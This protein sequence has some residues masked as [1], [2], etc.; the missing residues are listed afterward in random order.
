MS[1]STPLPSSPPSAS[2]A[3]RGA[4]R[5]ALRRA[6]AWST[7]LVLALYVLNSL[8][9]STEM[10]WGGE[11]AGHLPWVQEGTAILAVLAGLPLALWLGHRF[12]LERGRLRLSL[13][14]HA[15][16]M[17][18]YA[19]VQIG[20]MMG[21]R[22]LLWPVL[23]GRGYMVDGHWADVFVY[24]FR[25]QALVYA[26]FQI[27][28]AVNLALERR[29]LEAAAARVEART[30]HRITLKSGGRSFYP[31]AAN[32]LAAQAAG[33]YVEA[34]FGGREI[35]ARMTLT[36]LH[37]LLTEAGVDAVRT[38]RSFL[39]NRAAIAE[40]VPTGEGDVR[41][42]LSDGSEVPGSRRYRESLTL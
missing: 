29:R 39:V 19:L 9:I 14:A 17:L 30:S 38:H 20:L 15:A 8:S 24:E 21:S 22:E 42:V 10:R 23:Y 7:A 35:L 5:R 37:A 1:A 18:V 31:D 40:T 13:P 41:I 28:L 26:G 16:G 11:R 34:R 6:A 27:I 32:F 25:K 12:P 33:N 4:E 3:E 2:A 36:E